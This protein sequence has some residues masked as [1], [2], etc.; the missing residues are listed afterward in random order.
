MSVNK[1]TVEENTFFVNGYRLAAK[2]WNNC[3]SKKIIALHGWLDNAAS[4]DVL[5]P[6]LHDCHVV[7]LDLPG[8]GLSDHKSLQASYNLWDDLQDVLSVADHLEWSSF[9]ILGHSRGAMMALLLAAVVPEKIEST[10]LLDGIWPPP[11]EHEASV[12]QLRQYL[13]DQK[14]FSTRENSSYRSVDEAILAR[15]TASKMSQGSAAL[16][17][18]RGLKKNNNRYQWRFDPRLRGAS[19]F[20][21]TAEHIR[22]FTT[23]VTS[24]CLLLLA[25]EGIGDIP[26]LQKLL[27]E[28]PQIELHVLPGRH[29]FHMEEQ[30]P[31]IAG[32]LNAFLGEI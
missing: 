24:P 1:T 2:E 6:L 30:A 23:A 28:F 25:E 26:Q 22:V 5:A 9:T 3:A 27:L 13:F 17:V 16:I 18:S 31:E 10:I 32:Y 4:F 19:A 12:Q 29:H 8:H 11:V 20:K 21:L 14:K 15:R 7:A